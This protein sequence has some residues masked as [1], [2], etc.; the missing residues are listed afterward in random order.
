MHVGRGGTGARAAVLGAIISVSW[1][2]VARAQFIY[3][4]NNI[5]ISNSV[6]ALAV[7][8]G[9]VLSPVPGSPF[10]TGGGGSFSPDVDAIDAVVSAGRLY[11]AN[12]VSDNVSAFTINTDG[13]LTT[14]PGSPFPTANGP[15]LGLQP[16]GMAINRAG[17]R[18]FV[19]NFNSND[20]S[21]YDIA[22][23][24]A[25]THVPG[26]PFAVAANPLAVDI[27]S[28]NSRLFVSHGVLGVGVYT[29]GVGGSLTPVAGSP[30]PAGTG[31]R[32]IDVDLRAAKTRRARRRLRVPVFRSRGPHRRNIE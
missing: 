24:G 23:N 19:A 5:G 9:G 26:S 32:G 28:A 25:L 8:P 14:I 4:N 27:D 31:E 17:A 1:P 22:S 7:G 12:A 18:L 29:I 10:L 13:T 16:N 20:V 30:F 11:V 15:T 6:S 2:A 21:V 3:V